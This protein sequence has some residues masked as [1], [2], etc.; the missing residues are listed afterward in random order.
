M[1]VWGAR[2]NPGRPPGFGG[3]VV[4][5]SGVIAWNPCRYRGAWPFVVL[6]SCSTRPAPTM[7]GASA[8]QVS[9]VRPPEPDLV[10]GDRHCDERCCPS[11]MRV[12]RDGSG[13]AEDST[14]T[15]MVACLVGSREADELRARTVGSVIVAGD[16]DDVVTG[17]PRRDTVMADDGDD[18]VDGGPGSDH[19]DGGFGDD[20]IAGGPHGDLILGGPGDDVIFGEQESG[21]SD[22]PGP[23]IIHGGPGRDRIEGGP[24]EDEI[25]GGVGADVL[26]GGDDDDTLI[27]HRGDDE[28]YGGQGRDWLSGGAGD[29]ESRGG[30]GG[31]FIHS[32]LGRDVAYGEEGNDTFFINGECELQ[33]GEIIDGGPGADTVHSPLTEDELRERGVELV[34]IETFRLWG[35]RE[36]RPGGTI[37]SET[38]CRA[39]DPTLAV[40]EVSGEVSGLEVMWMDEER[41]LRRSDEVRT[42]SWSVVTLYRFHVDTV[43]LGDTDPGE[44]LTVILPGGSIRRPQGGHTTQAACCFRP[45]EPQRRYRLVLRELRARDGTQQGWEYEMLTESPPNHS[46]VLPLGARGSISLASMEPFSFYGPPCPGVPKPESLPSNR[47]AII[48]ANSLGYRWD[49]SV[50]ICGGSDPCM[51]ARPRAFMDFNM[52]MPDECS[53]ISNF[54]IVF[55]DAARGIS[56]GGI[57]DGTWGVHPPGVSTNPTTFRACDSSELEDGINCI[58]LDLPRPDLGGA[59]QQL[60]LGGYNGRANV[61]S[62]A[63]MKSMSWPTLEEAQELDITLRHDLPY[64]DVCEGLGPGG[65]SFYQL[66]TH[67]LGHTF[68]LA[69]AEDGCDVNMYESQVARWNVHEESRFRV[70]YPSHEFEFPDNMY[71]AP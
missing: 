1:A 23:D 20:R 14:Q 60:D 16:G 10:V 11:G 38:V 25:F 18:T 31:D 29:D 46:L 47:R 28:L 27:G 6:L 50:D 8:G 24:G 56:N 40:I 71:V 61:E 68:G 13:G 48:W 62:D 70:L 3:V 26:R 63:T 52:M 53:S 12:A 55:S 17:S 64:G 67:E 65:F 21:S 9:P 51:I 43:Y 4:D 45:I 30:P 58:A 57:L 7:E 33:P 19:L 54:E 41:R 42:G 36:H 59:S 35:A 5:S 32:G 34:S 69:H 44:T 66:V 37:G 22:H 2:M 15:D 49:Q 39:Q